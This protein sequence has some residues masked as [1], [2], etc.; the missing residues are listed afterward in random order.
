ML[1]NIL[2][3]DTLRNAGIA[4]GAIHVDSNNMRSV[5]LPGGLNM[6]SIGEAADALNS[7]G[8]DV[9]GYGSFLP[10]PHDDFVGGTITIVVDDSAEMATETR[11]ALRA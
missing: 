10:S 2:I 5:R 1:T 7:A 11:T 9:R 6:N 8:I 3:M 4:Q